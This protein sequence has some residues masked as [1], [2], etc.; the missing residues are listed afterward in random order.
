MSQRL[1][2]PGG[3]IAVVAPS[4]HISGEYLHDG[5]E[6]LRSAGF[7][8]DLMPHVAGFSQGVFSASDAQRAEDLHLALSDP[9][10]DAV[11]CTRGGYGAMRTLESLEPYGGWR[12]V[13]VQT[14]KVV[15]GFSDIT[16]LHSASTVVGKC[17]VL[18]PMLKHIATH[19]LSSPDVQATLAVLRGDG[20][21][22]S[23]PAMTGSRD[24]VAEGRVIGGNLS[25]VYSL[26]FT[27]LLPPPDGAILFIEDLSEYRYHIDRMIRA[28]RFSGY[29]SRLAGLVVGQMTGMR[30]GATPF[31]A[32]AFQIIA[33][34]VADYHYP[35][36]IG[37]PSGHAPEE[38][39]PLVIGGHAR[40]EVKDGLGTLIQRQKNL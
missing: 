22:L 25:I 13:F 17:G 27:E 8:V 21:S 29:L 2:Q 37:Y 33:E 35:L 14:D 16:T 9:R 31:G 12:E 28:L 32:D 30:D 11:W 36:F 23:R 1:L 20:F 19:G 15:V 7:S 34:A 5:V 38:N 39:Y 3:H 6:A 26:A 4:G 10:Y 18:G 40:L 24:G